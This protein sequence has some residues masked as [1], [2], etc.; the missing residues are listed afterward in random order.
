MKT[1]SL[2]GLRV[3]VVEDEFTVL[4]M[5]EHML[6]E[7][8]CTLAGSASRLREA[9]RMARELELDAAVLDV[10]INGQSISPVVGT[11]VDRGIPVVFSTGY[12]RGGID[13]Q[14]RTLPVLQKPYGTE[15][16]RAALQRALETQP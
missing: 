8:G 15:D 5:V 4:L 1:R 2:D 6:V 3:L 7:L 9:T 10:N 16:L 11:L 14:W 13:P 12:G